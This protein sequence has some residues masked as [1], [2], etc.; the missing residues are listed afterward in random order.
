MRRN[1]WL[2][3]I[4]GAAM[5]VA[6]L[7]PTSANAATNT[8]V[9]LGPAGY[10][11]NFA[12]SSG[13]VSLGKE[14]NSARCSAAVAKGNATFH[15]PQCTTRAIYCPLTANGCSITVN[16]QES[17]VRGPVAFYSAV[18]FIGGA[19]GTQTTLQAYNCPQANN[20]GVRTE[21]DGIAPGEGVQINVSNGFYAPNYPNVFAQVTMYIL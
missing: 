13:T 8:I 11:S 9:N 7:V 1:L 5:I 20:C 21:F 10:T 14:A 12:S 18:K 4:A 2:A 17:A 15:T 16:A 19:Y 6:V 3:A